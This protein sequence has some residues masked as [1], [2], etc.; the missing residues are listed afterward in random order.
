MKVFNEVVRTN[1][2]TSKEYKINAFSYTIKEMASN[3]C[4]NYM[5]EF[6]IC[7]FS[8]LTQTFY[9]HHCKMQ[10]DK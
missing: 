4:H 3:W 5:S 9:K 8:K 7:S 6:P 10:N 2:E 1:G